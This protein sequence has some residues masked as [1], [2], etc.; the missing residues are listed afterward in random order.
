MTAQHDL[1]RQLSA[2][3]VDGPTRLPDASFDAVRDRT[4]QTR[5]RVVLGPW[6]F[7]EMNKLLAIGLGAAAVVAALLVG[8][9]LL[10]SSGVGP[11]GQPAASVEP[12][13]AA[14][15]T[16]P[17]LAPPSVEPEPSGAFLPEGPFVVA[18]NYKPADAPSITITIP[19]SGWASAPEFGALTKGE[20]ADPPESVILAWPHSPGTGFN[21]YGDPCKWASTEP[22]APATTAEDFAAALA[23]QPGRDAS[24]PVDVIIAGY[25][26]KR[27]TLHVPD[28]APTRDEAFKDCDQGNYAS[29]G[30]EGVDEPSRYHQGPGQVDE[31]WILDV[32]GAIVTID[33]AYRPDTSTER[34]EEMRAMVESATFD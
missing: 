28:D 26:G 33:V 30:I 4:E 29:F 21:V 34:I 20:D 15:S 23:A 3:L 5:Q 9:N 2:F 31:I 19:S 12:S 7:A 17:S 6:R 13:S 16:G 27:V 22:E 32:D 10:P 18:D 25:Q 11:G 8:P 1:D 14:P 24:D